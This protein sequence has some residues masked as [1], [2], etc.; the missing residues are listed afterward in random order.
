MHQ[1]YDDNMVGDSRPKKKKNGTGYEG[2]I[3]YM[4]IHIQIYMGSPSEIRSTCE[5][6]G[7]S[8]AEKGEIIQE[9]FVPRTSYCCTRR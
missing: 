2:D 3:L 5:I 6:P 8:L 1:Y 9:A 4:Y 7:V